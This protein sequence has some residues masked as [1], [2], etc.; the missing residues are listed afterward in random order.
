M[1]R[2]PM[3]RAAA[4]AVVEVFRADPTVAVVLAEISTDLFEPAFRHDPQ[5]AV[6]VGIMEQSLVGVAAGFALEG[7]R[8][9]VHTIAPFLAERALE[10][11]KLDFGYQRLEGLFVSTGASYDYA[12]SGMTHH[13]PG[14][15]AALSTVPGMEILVPGHRAEAGALV[16]ETYANA[17]PTY[18]RTTAAENA[19]ARALE[20]G[21]LTVVQRGRELTAIAVGPMLDRTLAALHGVDATV[22]Y[23]TTVF[24]LDA[25]T[26]ASE[27]AGAAEF[28]VVEPFY[29]GTLAGEVTAALAH[30]PTRL[31]SIGV[32]RRAIHEYGTVAEHDRALG[33]DTRAIR[34]RV[35]GF[36]D[37][38]GRRAA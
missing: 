35:L 22:L 38:T 16:H 2:E 26:L 37:R 28:V 4:E 27:A 21:G 15:V 7:F 3:R 30:R 1:A 14:D 20:P 12:S 18:L 19:D 17:R 13:S 29:A 25:A 8:P 5:R 31:L 36:L 10:Q 33:L 23:A 24:P 9:V 34:D 11:V 6:N 32:P